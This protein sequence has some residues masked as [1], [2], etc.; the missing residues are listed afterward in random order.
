VV[1]QGLRYP[2]KIGGLAKIVYTILGTHKSYRVSTRIGR[3]FCAWL[4]VYRQSI[5]FLLAK[6]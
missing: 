3:T 5:I 2:K 6:V 4:S 1:Y